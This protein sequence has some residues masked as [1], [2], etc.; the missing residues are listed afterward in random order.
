MGER[1]CEITFENVRVPA[2][3]LVGAEGEGFKLAQ[4]WINHG[5]IRHG[6]RG[7]GVAARCIELATGYATQRK[8][9]GAPLSDRQGIQWMMA[10]AY[11]EMHAT[12][13][14]V[15]HAAAKRLSRERHAAVSQGP[16]NVAGGPRRGRGM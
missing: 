5:R 7:V 6:S 8:T 12:R 10:D 14:M 9:F 11:T 1:P 15:R 13:L 16:R 4:G 2:H 3:N